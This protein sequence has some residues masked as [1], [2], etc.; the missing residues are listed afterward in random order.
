VSDNDGGGGDVVND[1]ETPD[2]VEQVDA[3]AKTVISDDEQALDA[4]A[5]L[6]LTEQAA[7]FEALHDELR[8]LLDQ[9]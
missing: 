3:D 8:Q 4:I 7:A 9:R 5:D 2:V 1:N 6:P